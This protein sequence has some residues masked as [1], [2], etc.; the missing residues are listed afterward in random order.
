[1][2]VDD[3]HIVQLSRIEDARGSLTVIEGETDIPFAIRR[4]YWLYD[5]PGGASRAGHAHKTLRQL[6]VSMSGSCDI[7]LDDGRDKKTY[8]L[9]R[10][11]IGL[12]VHPMTWREID[13]FSSNSVLL[14]LASAHYDEADYFRDYGEFSRAARGA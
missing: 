6:I 14:V 7:H 2:S 11:Y 3:C 1:M 8:H 10:S 5:V 12:Y 4:T 13:N 9:N